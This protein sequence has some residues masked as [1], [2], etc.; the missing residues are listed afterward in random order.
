MFDESLF[1]YKLDTYSL[2]INV[3]LD[4]LRA[5]DYWVLSDDE[6]REVISDLVEE[7]GSYDDFDT[8]RFALQIFIP[9][10]YWYNRKLK[11]LN[12]ID[13]ALEWFSSEQSMK[14]TVAS[15]I[16]AILA[17]MMHQIERDTTGKTALFMEYYNVVKQHYD[18][19]LT[20]L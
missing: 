12:Y 16:N 19:Y 7:Y 18:D 15:L 14:D 11:F 6:K 8:D 17:G 2:N 5:V 3:L 10:G 4:K 20:T 9:I 13:D 1:L